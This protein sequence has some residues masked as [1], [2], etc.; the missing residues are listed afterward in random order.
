MDE[1]IAP[2]PESLPHFISTNLS[3]GVLQLRMLHSPPVTLYKF[4]LPSA[5]L[6]LTHGAASHTY[7]ILFPWGS[8]IHWKLW[9]DS[10]VEWYN[11][12][13]YCSVF[14]KKN[15]TYY[16]ERQPDSHRN[17]NFLNTSNRTFFL[18]LIFSMLSRF[19]HWK[20]PD[21]L[22]RPWFPNSPG[23]EKGGGETAITA[24]AIPHIPACDS[25]L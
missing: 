22:P 1:F 5:L 13:I 15:V 4:P 18:C 12:T 23:F 3:R 11:S 16:Q 19:D 14:D 17:K 20:S 7:I 10:A 24:A 9:T 25:L 6:N 8:A 2:S 21:L